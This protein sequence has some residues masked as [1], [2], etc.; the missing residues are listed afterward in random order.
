MRARPR[1]ALRDLRGRAV[2][3]TCAAA[4]LRAGAPAARATSAAGN[5]SATDAAGWPAWSST[6]TATDANPGVTEP[7]SSRSRRRGPRR[8]RAAGAV[9]DIGPTPLRCTNA[10]RDGNSA[11]S[12]A[13]GSAASIAS[14]DAVSVAGRRTPTSVTRLGRPAARSSITY[15]TSRPCS[16]ARWPLWVLASTSRESTVPAIQRSGS[17]RA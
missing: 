7:S 3:A 2:A 8:A 16:T 14:P 10:R 4:E 9:S 12:C 11:R 13:A 1:I 15:S 5:V 17:W 6:A